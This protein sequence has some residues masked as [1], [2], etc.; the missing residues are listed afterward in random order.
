M[1]KSLV[2][3]VLGASC[4]HAQVAKEANAGYRDEQGRKQVASRLNDPGRE[5]RQRPMELLAAIGLKSGMSIADIGTGVGF[6]LPYMSRA[7]GPSGTVYAE[8]I[9][10]DFL[11]QA[12]DHAKD[13]TNVRFVRGNERSASLPANSIDRALILDA[14]HHFDYPKEM[15]TSIASALKAQRPDCDCGVRK[16]R[17]RHG[18][19]Q[20]RRTHSFE[21]RRVCKGNRE[22]RFSRFQRQR[23][24]AR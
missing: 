17:S 4:L 21:P 18:R 15:L 8:D 16:K 22:F 7:V 2:S 24:Y 13:L 11:A 14:Y 12:K 5:A 3:I 6:M 19:A 23:I 9:F 10:P 1:I 20:F